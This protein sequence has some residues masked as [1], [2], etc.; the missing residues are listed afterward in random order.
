MKKGKKFVAVLLIFLGCVP[1]R[2][3]ASQGKSS[4]TIIPLNEENPRIYEVNNLDFGSHQQTTTDVNFPAAEDLSI[5]IF[6]QRVISKSWS[7]QVKVGDF[8][9]QQ[10]ATLPKSNF[11]VG[12][13][14]PIGED[15]NGLTAGSYSSTISD[16]YQ[17]ILSSVSN[18]NRGWLEY[19]IPKENITI[20]F[21]EGA[22]IGKYQAT[23]YWRMINAET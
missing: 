20:S 16:D 15:I 9:N 10:I 1:I 11:T 8:E 23:A 7:L 17:T 21:G 4:L 13:G 5:K 22:T 12:K 18:H 14:E 2:A 19:H 6:D 3:L